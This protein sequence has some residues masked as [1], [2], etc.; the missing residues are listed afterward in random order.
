[1]IDAVIKDQD[2][3]DEVYAVADKLT[4]S[5]LQQV[6]SSINGIFIQKGRANA[7][8]VSGIAQAVDEIFA[9]IF[10]D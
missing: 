3:R 4:V 9:E 7:S 8:K 10:A 2:T 5:Q 6:F 1:M